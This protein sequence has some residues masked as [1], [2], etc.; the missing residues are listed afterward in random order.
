MKRYIPLSYRDYDPNQPRDPKGSPT[1]GRW[2][3]AASGLAAS[4]K[5]TG[6]F[7]YNVVGKNSLKPGD[8]VFVVSPYKDRERVFDK[9]KVTDLAQYVVDNIDLLSKDGH[10]FGGWADPDSGKVFLDVSIATPDQNQAAQICKDKK[11]LAYFNMETM[12][13]VTVGKTD[14]QQD[15]V[16]YDKWTTDNDRRYSDLVQKFNRQ[17]S[18]SGGDQAGTEDARDESTESGVGDD[19]AEVVPDYLQ[20]AGILLLTPQKTSLFLRRVDDGTWCFPGG[21]VELGEDRLDAALREYAEETGIAAPIG[22]TVEFE[23]TISPQGVDFTT[24]VM[25]VEEEFTPTLDPD[26][27]DDWAWEPVLAPPE[28]VH[29]GVAFTLS[30]APLLADHDSLPSVEA[31]DAWTEEARRAALAARLANRKGEITEEEAQKHARA[32]WGKYGYASAHRSFTGH[33]KPGP[34]GWVRPEGPISYYS[35]GYKRKGKQGRLL[36]TEKGKSWAGDP[37]AGF[38]QALENATKGVV[39]DAW[40]E[41]AWRAS[42]EA[43]SR[44]RQEQNGPRGPARS[45]RPSYNTAPRR[46]PIEELRARVIPAVMS[47]GKIYSG[48]YG[49]IH[50][51]IVTP[52]GERNLG[53]FDPQTRKFYR[54]EELPFDATDLPGYHRRLNLMRSS[55]WDA[56]PEVGAVQLTIPLLIR[57]L[58]WAREDVKA[59]VPLHIAAERMARAKGCLGIEDYDNIV[60]DINLS[61]DSSEVDEEVFGPF[62]DTAWEENKHPRAGR[63]QRSGG[64]FVGK[65]GPNPAYG[66]KKP[67]S[68]VPIDK[69]WNVDF[70]SGYWYNTIQQKL[71]PMDSGSLGPHGDHDGWITIGDNA[72]K[73]GIDKKTAT[74]F[75][76]AT[77]GPEVLDKSNPY[78]KP[79]IDPSTGELYKWADLDHYQ[80]NKMFDKVFEKTFGITRDIAFADPATEFK[81]I[82]IRKWTNG[83]LSIDVNLLP[84]DKTLIE[85]VGTPLVLSGVKSVSIGNYDEVDYRKMSVAEFLS[86]SWLNRGKSTTAAFHSL[87]A[88][89]EEG[90]HPRGQAGKFSNKNKPVYGS[91]ARY[92]SVLP[93]HLKSTGIKEAVT[94][95]AWDLRKSSERASWG[96]KT[97][98]YSIETEIPSSWKEVKGISGSIRYYDPRV[99]TYSD[100]AGFRL[101]SDYDLG[102]PKK[103]G[104]IYRGMSFEEYER[105]LKEGFFGSKGEYNIGAAEKGLTYFSSE[106]EQAQSYAADFAPWQFL[107]T[108]DRPAVVIAVTDPGDHIVASGRPTE[109]GIKGQIPVSAIRSV[110]FGKPW[111]IKFGTIEMVSELGRNDMPSREG[112]RFSPSSAVYWEEQHI[113]ETKDTVFHSR[114]EPKGVALVLNTGDWNKDDGYATDC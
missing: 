39:D 98:T 10:Y 42:A 84:V 43:R 17:E 31:D 99:A 41:A 24:Y 40:T 34:D 23:R 13:T 57:I 68:F 103:A 14:D 48:A 113:S 89:W 107:P 109:L 53:F 25:G 56:E 86:G 69:N 26:E 55:N 12:E 35:V 9:I 36:S 58:E 73:I 80:Y 52:T 46:N 101:K 114:D 72:E 3:S 102:I 87:D 38:R 37:N 33:E 21:I 19:A 44:A 104:I 22:N 111:F 96:Q 110:Y 49:S 93:E 91:K 11:Q 2:S 50:E 71:V 100:D 75:Q 67:I 20:A 62:G 5:K 61:K 79:F 85:K 105:A 4:L 95:G 15:A 83:E 82:R 77:W 88:S 28:P 66:S 16:V 78:R 30:K 94:R 70:G 45:E 60:G 1:G 90:K 97:T 8:K 74:A 54:R 6:G 27:H 64:R 18:S 65:G 92:S 63:G 47:G 59:D 29:P 32:V 106:P 7:S 76:V 108:P 81:I 51:D 112:S